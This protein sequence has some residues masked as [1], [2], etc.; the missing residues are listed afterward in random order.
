MRLNADEIR[1]TVDQVRRLLQEET[2][3]SPTLR[4]TLE[5]LL[6]VVT[7]LLNRVG[8]N[9]R[10]SS[11]PPSASVGIAAMEPLWPR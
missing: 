2:T 10:N 3:I 4:A 1:S 8:L 11:K 5:M 9:S 6:V 7:I